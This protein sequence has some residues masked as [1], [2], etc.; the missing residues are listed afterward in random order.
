MEL[1]MVWFQSVSDSHT[2]KVIRE[3]IYKI[4]F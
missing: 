3:I 1:R 2:D 4:N